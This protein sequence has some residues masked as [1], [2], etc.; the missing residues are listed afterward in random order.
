MRREKMKRTKTVF[1]RLEKRCI[2]RSNGIFIFKKCRI[3]NFMTVF[4]IQICRRS[5]VGL[6]QTNFYGDNLQL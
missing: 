5:H 3:E 1:F 6:N 2:Y 4:E